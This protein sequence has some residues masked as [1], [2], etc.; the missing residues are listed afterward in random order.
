MLASL[1]YVHDTTPRRDP[2]Y[3]CPCCGYIVFT[4]P[5]GSYDICKICF[6]EDDVAQL[7]SPDLAGG[8]NDPSLID[9]QRTYAAIGAMEERFIGLVRPPFPHETIDP[10][11]RPFDIDRDLVEPPGQERAWPDDPTALYYWRPTFWLLDD[12]S[13]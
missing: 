11:W 13:G 8:A 6:W 9:A 3:P 4:E 1:P 5:P 12:H 10:G 2:R 7:S